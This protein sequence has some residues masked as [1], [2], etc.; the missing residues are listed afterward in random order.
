MAETDPN[1]RVTNAKIYA[2]LETLDDRLKRVE[3]TSGATAAHSIKCAA[4][5][6]EYDKRREDR[7]VKRDSNDQR[8]ANNLQRRETAAGTKQLAYIAGVVAIVVAVINLISLAL[9]GYL[10]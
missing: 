5:W 1:Q 7:D 6:E 8:Q 9:Q 3:T 4:R 10:G 2:K